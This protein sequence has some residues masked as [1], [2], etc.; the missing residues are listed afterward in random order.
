MVDGAYGKVS[1]SLEES[2]ANL[3]SNI[4]Q[5]IATFT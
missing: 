3:K 2:H 4:P 5:Y 1:K